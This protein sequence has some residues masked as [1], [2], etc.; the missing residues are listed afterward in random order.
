[1]VPAVLDLASPARIDALYVATLGFSKNN[2]AEMADLLDRGIIGRLSLLCSHYFK[3]T[4]KG[5]YEIAADVMAKRPAARFRSLRTHCKIL[6][7]R[8]TD[9]RTVT[10]ESSANLRSCKNIEQ[11]TVFGHPAVYEFHA[12]WM[13]T[14]FEDRT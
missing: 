14:L 6:A 12:G 1:M 13:N 10:I 5:I 4:S 2:V 8:L 9:G 11:M 3:G 7:L